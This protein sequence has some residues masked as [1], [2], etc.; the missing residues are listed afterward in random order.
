MSFDSNSRDKALTIT[1]MQRQA[2]NKCNGNQIEAAEYVE[3][4][5]GN[6]RRFDQYDAGRLARRAEECRTSGATLN[7]EDD[8]SLLKVR[9]TNRYGSGR[10]AS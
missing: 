2:L 1:Q 8:P 9:P 7:L 10:I 4:W 5:I 6:D 3:L